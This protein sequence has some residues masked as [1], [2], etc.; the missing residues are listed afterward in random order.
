[1]PL[2]RIGP[3]DAR[4]ALLT[5]S[6]SHRIRHRNSVLEHLGWTGVEAE[7]IHLEPVSKVHE[8]AS[9]AWGAFRASVSWMLC[10]STT[11]GRP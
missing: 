1:M 9:A 5:N 3:S 10:T 11:G 6:A 2:C 7:E 8:V 4:N